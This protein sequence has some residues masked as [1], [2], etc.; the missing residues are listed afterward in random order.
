MSSVANTIT[1]AAWIIA[2]LP[3][4]WLWGVNRREAGKDRDVAERVGGPDSGAS[5]WA[6]FSVL[7]TSTFV[8]IEAVFV[9]I[10]VAALLRP[11]PQQVMAAQDAT[12]DL[13][14]TLTRFVTLLGLVGAS[15][16]ISVLA[17]RWR[18]VNTQLIEQA[19]KRAKR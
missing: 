9:A 8:G 11:P 2:A 10:G 1:V 17:H 13:G 7:L 4:L 6:R 3:G 14:V 16:V 12:S 5:L 15:V 18:K 19:R